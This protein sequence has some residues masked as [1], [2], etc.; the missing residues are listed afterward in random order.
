MIRLYNGKVLSMNGHTLIKDYEV[1]VEEDMIL[2]VG[3]A[4]NDHPVFD[5]EIDLR[6]IC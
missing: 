1:W 6:A 4:S 3:P 5:R 2:Y